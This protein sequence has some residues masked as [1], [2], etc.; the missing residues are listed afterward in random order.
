MK[1]QEVDQFLAANKGAFPQD[2]MGEVREQLLKVHEA[3]WTKVSTLSFTNPVLV[4]ILDIVFWWTALDRFWL[5]QI[6]LGIFKLIT[7]GGCGIWALIDW[8]S[9]MKRVRQKNLDKLNAAL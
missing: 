6:G 2:M 9:V 1:A 3:D 7:C 8:F 5:G 4:L